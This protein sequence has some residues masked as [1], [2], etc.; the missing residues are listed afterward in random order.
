MLWLVILLRLTSIP[1]QGGKQ[2]RKTGINVTLVYIKEQMLKAA[3]GEIIFMV[4][5]D[6]Q[7]VRDKEYIK[8]VKTL[9]RLFDGLQYRTNGLYLKGIAL[10]ECYDLCK[11]HP[12]LYF[13][14]RTEQKHGPEHNFSLFGLDNIVYFLNVL[15]LHNTRHISA[16]TP[17]H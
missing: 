8:R 10:W 3:Q 9:S 15:T 5:F 11:Q 1:V 12:H 13:L 2:E 14:C 7:L 6:V 16:E 17:Q 4:W